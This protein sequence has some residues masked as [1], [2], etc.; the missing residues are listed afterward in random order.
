ML[1]LGLVLAI[2][3][4]C[5]APLPA[6]A[7]APPHATTVVAVEAFATPSS[8][9]AV[10]V[11]PAD[12][13]VELTGDAEPGFLAIYYDE[14]VVWVPAQFLSLGSLPGID[15]AVAVRDTPLLEAPLPDAHSLGLVPQGETVILTGA[16][17][18][19]FNAGSSDGTGGWLTR[20]DLER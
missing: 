14:Q 16:R 5:A 15:T 12:T 8:G 7:K 1:K 19:D 20:A 3:F 17:V 10:V 2:L 11:I 9:E 4:G 18:G 13:E 6:L